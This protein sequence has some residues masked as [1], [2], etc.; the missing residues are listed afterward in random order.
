MVKCM[1]KREIREEINGKVYKTFS[2]IAR[3]Y[4]MYPSTVIIRYDRGL[5]GA[6]LVAKRVIRNPKKNIKK[7][8]KHIDKG[9]P[10]KIEGVVYNK[11][12]DLADKYGINQATLRNGIAAGFTGDE[13]VKP[14]TKSIRGRSISI[15][16]I[17]YPSLSAAAKELGFDRMKLRRL[18]YS[19]YR[20]DELLTKMKCERKMQRF[21][22]AVIFGTEYT[23]I[24]DI[25][26]KFNIPETTLRG[27]YQNGA[28]DEQLICNKKGEFTLPGRKLPAFIRFKEAQGEYIFQRTYKNE[29][30]TKGRKRFEDIMAISRLVDDYIKIFDR[31]PRD[32]GNDTIKI[33]YNTILGKQFGE[34]FVKGIVLQDNKRKLWCVCSCG[35][36]KYYLP[37]GVVE[38]KIKSCGHLEGLMLTQKNEE[39]KEIQ[40]NR[41]VALASNTTTGKKNISYNN[42]KKAFEFKITR[43]ETSLF[44][45]F[46]T[47]DQALEYKQKVLNY[48]KK[49]DGKLPSKEDIK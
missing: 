12:S 47:L 39:L 2:E 44:Q 43:G 27:R 30:V 34:L 3:D 19:G 26:L 36:E 24:R 5:R 48:I 21:T 28:R 16:G 45:R 42:S 4:S 41:D 8:K 33:D 38:G 23:R 40:R 29:T 17:D 37:P 49:H 6:E 1:G 31:L 22:G 10:L 9:F 14:V 18:Y 25:A 35:K 32:L 7:P 46:K 20:D 13:I 11:V 15:N